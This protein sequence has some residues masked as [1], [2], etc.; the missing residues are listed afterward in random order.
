MDKKLIALIVLFFIS[1]AFFSAVLVFNKPITQFT[2][3]K[4]EI[5][6]SAEKS[7]IIAW[8][9]PSIKADGISESTITVF[10]VSQT[11]KPLSNKVITLISSIGQLKE[12]SAVTDNDGKAAFHISSTNPGIA[13][14]E[15]IAEPSIK[16]SKKI[17]LKFE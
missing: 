17:S 3:A 9:F 14:I 6:P 5:T 11:G 16:L 10:I 1:F 8:P 2:R 13:Q 7:K 15:A 12:S 4:E